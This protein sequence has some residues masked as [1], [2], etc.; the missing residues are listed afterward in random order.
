MFWHLED[1][2][3][4]LTSSQIKQALDP[5][6]LLNFDHVVRVRKPKAGE[7]SEW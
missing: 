6:Y 1:L 3:L 4:L 7:V 2:S 5:L